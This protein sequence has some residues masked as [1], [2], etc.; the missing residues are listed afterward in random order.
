MPRAAATFTNH[1]HDEQP[2]DDRDGT[3]LGRVRIERTFEGDIAGEGTAELLTARAAD[4]TAVYLAFDR[5][6]GRI[7]DREGSFVLAHRG[8]VTSE[9]ASTAG[10]VVAGSGTGGLRGLTGT[11]EIAVED[12]V[13]RLILDYELSA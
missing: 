10:E 1:S 2:Y 11:A 12:G 13:H 7:A 5:I 8:T 4:G 9:G 6:A 3:V